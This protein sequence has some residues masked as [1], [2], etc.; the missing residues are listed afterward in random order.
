MDVITFYYFLI[1]ILVVGTI[2][3]YFSLK[4]N[5]DAG[6]SDKFFVYSMIF[7]SSVMVI[8]FLLSLFKIVPIEKILG[9]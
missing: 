1:P 2:W 9:R 6:F 7:Y 8:L 3:K 4:K 5:K